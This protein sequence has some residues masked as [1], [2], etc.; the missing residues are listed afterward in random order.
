MHRIFAPA[1]L[2]CL[3]LS[4]L[5]PSA[6][7]AYVDVLDAAKTLDGPQLQPQPAPIVPVPLGWN[8]LTVDCFAIGLISGTNFYAPLVLTDFNDASWSQ[9]VG[10]EAYAEAM[11]NPFPVAFNLNFQ[12]PLVLGTHIRVAGYAAGNLIANVEGTYYGSDTWLFENSDE[13]DPKGQVPEP[14]TLLLL[15]GGLAMGALRRSRRR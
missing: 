12:D 15:G 2:L 9:V 8:N 1:L 11:G 10:V 4:A 3:G 14:V 6:Q 5:A 13:W 7:A